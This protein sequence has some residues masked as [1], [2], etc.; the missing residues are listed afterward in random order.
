MS[1]PH[2]LISLIAVQIL[3]R[4]IELFEL[5]E[6]RPILEQMV[7]IK[8]ELDRARGTVKIHVETPDADA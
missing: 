7:E 2:T 6:E 4:I 1:T 5:D 3:V 8:E